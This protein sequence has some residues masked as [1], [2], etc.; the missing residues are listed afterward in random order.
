MSVVVTVQ[1]AHA[2]ERSPL[3]V[4]RIYLAAERVVD[5]EGLTALTMRRL[6]RELGVEAMSVYHHVP[7]KGALERGL[8]ERLA[9]SAN[10]PLE[11]ADPVALLDGHCRG[12]RTALLRR[13]ALVPLVAT[14]LP[15]ALFEAP[16]STAVR[17]RLVEF[18]FDDIAA[19]WILDAF[20]GYVVGHAMVER[21]DA[22]ATHDD[23]EAAFETGLR[24]L[25]LGLR[26]E[27]GM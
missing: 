20:I 7:N 18:G 19:A 4:E 1:N 9:G 26:D 11:A 23:D 12:L 14:H 8:V 10:G 21:S 2:T 3:D 17:E 22:R 15:R 25:L 24:F 13:P 5:T 27:L 6:G 16:A